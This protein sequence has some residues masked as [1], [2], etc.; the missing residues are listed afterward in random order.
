MKKKIL[1]FLVIILLLAGAGALLAPVLLRN[2]RTDQLEELAGEVVEMDTEGEENS[3]FDP[4]TD[5]TVDFSALKEINSDIYAWIYVPGTEVNYPIMQSSSDEEEDYY[6][7]H[8]YDG[9]VGYP[10]SIYTQK[11]TSKYF[12]DPNT[13]IYG[14]NMKNGSMF[15]S[16]HNYEDEN[17]LSEY[18]YIYVYTADASYEY[19]VFAAYNTDNNLI[20]E[21]Y[22]DFSDEDVFASYIEEILEKTETDSTAVVDS[23]V[24]VDGGDLLVTLSTCL[25]DA[26]RRFLVQGVLNRTE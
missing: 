25:G 11:R 26:D 12:T 14:H 4:L 5:I 6:L 10:A 3:T 23:S 15:A 24:T 1:L 13:V 20:L 18:P 17:F 22:D 21:E 7:N 8:N 9:S 16:L 2:Y 19:R